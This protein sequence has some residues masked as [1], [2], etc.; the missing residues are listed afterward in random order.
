MCIYI[1]IYRERERG[2]EMYMFYMYDIYNIN[3]YTIYSCVLD[4]AYINVCT[5]G[6]LRCAGYGWECSCVQDAA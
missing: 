6:I 5:V 2:R 1:Y 3:Y 4:T